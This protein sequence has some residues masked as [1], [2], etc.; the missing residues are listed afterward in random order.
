MTS[1]EEAEKA[2]FKLLK[3]LEP[4][5]TREGLLNTPRRVV[6]SWDEIFQDIIPILL[7]YWKLR[8]MLKV[9]MESYF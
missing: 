2:V 6:D 9:M 1:R 5:P 3:Y 7:A 4:D 8:S